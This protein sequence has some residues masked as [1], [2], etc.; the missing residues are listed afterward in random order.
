M[1]T[2]RIPYLV[3]ACTLLAA[4]AHAAP[5]AT[6][7]GTREQLRACLDLD[8]ALKTRW[9]AIDAAT[10][11]HNRKFDA[12]ESEDAQLV[13]MKAKL[14][15]NDKNAISAFNQAVQA[16]GQ[17]IRQVNQEGDELEVTSK[18]YAADRAAADA[19]CGALTYR[20]ADIDAVAKERKK[21][22]AVAAASASAP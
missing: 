1:S 15:R 7:F 14:D 16:H 17:H 19:K 10:A 6:A 22:A 2:S 20:P 11:E 8:D 18:A 4:A 21:A 12:N 5:P 3:A 13:E 9:H